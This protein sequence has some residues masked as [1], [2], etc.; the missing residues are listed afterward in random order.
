MC[1]IYSGR[2]RFAVLGQKHRSNS[3]STQRPCSGS[4]VR[5]IT[6]VGKRPIPEWLTKR[7][8]FR[9]EVRSRLNRLAATSLRLGDLW[10]RATQAVQSASRAAMRII[11]QRPA[12]DA[13]TR[14]QALLQLVRALVRQ[15]RRLFRQSSGCFR[16]CRR[17]SMFIGRHRNFGSRSLERYG[18]VFDARS[19]P[20][21]CGGRG[22]GRPGPAGRWAATPTWPSKALQVL[23]ALWDPL[24]S[25]ALMT[26]VLDDQGSSRRMRRAK[27]PPWQSIGRALS[28]PDRHRGPS[29]KQSL[30]P[31]PE[32]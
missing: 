26:T 20:G 8:P 22:C 9:A 21:R 6:L 7:A 31:A 5:K 2:V 19:R 14:R 23:H 16:A 10:R 3:S 1:S 17:W 12:E 15:D 25:R 32:S 18:G 29:L 13:Q 27:R 28:P 4:H 11:I 30:P 24:H